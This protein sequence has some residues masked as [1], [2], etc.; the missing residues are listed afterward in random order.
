MEWRVDLGEC[1]RCG[2]HFQPRQEKAEVRHVGIIHASCMRD[3]E[4]LA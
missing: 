3:G 1:E 4:C 2:E